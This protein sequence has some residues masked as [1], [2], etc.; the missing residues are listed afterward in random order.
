MPKKKRPM[1]SRREIAAESYSTCLLA[2]SGYDV[3]VQ[4]GAHQEDFDLVATK[5]EKTL[6]ISVKGTQDGGWMLAVRY[7]GP[8]VGYIAAINQWLEAQLKELVYMVVSFL[9]PRGEAPRVY[10]ARPEEIAEQMRAQSAGQGKAVLR[11]D[12]PTH[13]PHAKH[14]DKIPDSW[15]YSTERID[16]F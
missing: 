10:I 16:G 3:F 14:Q 8:R 1:T 2:Q 15:H 7:L 13:H 9:V 12:T 6:R 5:N 4:Y 11:E